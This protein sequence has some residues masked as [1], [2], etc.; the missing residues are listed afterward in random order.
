MAVNEVGFE[1]TSCENTGRL[2]SWSVT[3]HQGV[4]LIRASVVRIS[5]LG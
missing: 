1:P 4:M 3:P 5:G 2:I